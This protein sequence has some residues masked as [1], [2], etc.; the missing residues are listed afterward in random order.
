MRSS[1]TMAL[2][3]YNTWAHMTVGRARAHGV[4]ERGCTAMECH[5]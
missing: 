3:P 5:G 4:S 2:A 1:T